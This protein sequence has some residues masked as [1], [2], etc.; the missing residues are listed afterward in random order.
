MQLIGNCG[1]GGRGPK[2]Q[3]MSLVTAAAQPTAASWQDPSVITPHISDCAFHDGGLAAKA[4]QFQ[5]PSDLVP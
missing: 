3:V 1:Q 2:K 5:I 4:K